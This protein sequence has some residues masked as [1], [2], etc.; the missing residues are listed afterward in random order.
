MNAIALIPAY[1]PEA[2][3]VEYVQA[4]LA[5]KFDLVVVVNDGSDSKHDPVFIQLQGFANVVLLEHA[6]NLGKGAALKTGLNYIA[7]NFP[8]SV[9][10]VT[11]D[12]DGQ[13]L[14]K[15]AAAIGDTLNANSEKLIL[16]TRSFD[17]EV[18]LRSKIGNLLTRYVFKLV[19]GTGIQ[20]TQS[21]LRGIPMSLIRSLLLITSNGYEFE[22]DMLILAHR[23]GYG[24]IQHPISTVYLN[25]NRSS[26]FQPL[27]DSLRVYFV[28]FRFTIIALLSALIDYAIF[29]GL[30]YF[31][32]KDVMLCMIGGRMV[33][34][35]FNYLNVKRYAFHFK[36]HHQKALP[37][38]VALVLIS[39]LLAYAMVTGLMTEFGLHAITAKLIAEL[40]MFVVNFLVQRDLIFRKQKI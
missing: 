21:G 16:G 24:I 11:I 15:D 10:V 35:I 3:L 34:G 38:Y 9:G 2:S 40:I 25:G 5:T 22:L 18:P 1:D 31:V 7:C 26:H 30:Y 6:I 17:K 28:L 39:L 27:W 20:D 36:G 29:V 37:K 8:D 14:L 12:A 13:H 33:S 4:L 23:Y 19:V 32:F